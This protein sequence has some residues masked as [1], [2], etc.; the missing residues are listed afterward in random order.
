MKKFTFIIFFALASVSAFGEVNS[1]EE[2]L[3]YVADGTSYTS[4]TKEPSTF[5]VELG[6]GYVNARFTGEQSAT[7]YRKKVKSSTSN[8]VDI[9]VN[10]IYQPI[11]YFGLSFGL[12]W[13]FLPIKWQGQGLIE[14]ESSIL[15][16]SNVQ[17]NS[18]EFVWNAVLTL[19]IL[20]D[21][22]K[23]N[24]NSI[25]LFA[26]IGAGTNY[27]FGGSKYEGEAS[28]FSTTSYTS[29]T[30]II[31]LAFAL[32]VNFGVRFIFAKA[33]GIEIVGKYE[34]IDKTYKYK[35]PG[36]TIQTTISRDMSF[37]LRYVYRFQF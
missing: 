16:D 35:Y 1:N 28:D 4:A 36:K 19:G 27:L 11:Q 14:P 23:D 5:F 29:T 32:P 26:N 34:L 6:V 33:H 10:G 9:F 30:Q 37:G 21:I 7:A 12:L 18:S 25:R 13:E 2:V 3:R 31:P 15:A 24:S 17:Y 22:Y 8:G 20:S